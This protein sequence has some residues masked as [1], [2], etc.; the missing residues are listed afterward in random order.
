M[1]SLGSRFAFYRVEVDER[2]SQTRRALI[3]RRGAKE[4]RNELREAVSALFAGIT[5][6]EEDALTDS[7][8]DRLVTVADLVTMARSPI[9]RDRYSREI[10]LVP[11]P[12][13]PARF[14]LIL[15]SLLEGLY[16]IGVEREHA[17]KLVT[18]VA[19]DSMPAQR[20]Q[21]IRLLAEV[22]TTTTKKV[23]MGLGLPTT[24]ARR[25]LE[26]LT[27]HRLVQREEGEDD[28]SDTWR[29]TAWTRDKYRESTV[30]A[31]SV[32]LCPIYPVSTND[33]FAGTMF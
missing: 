18:K 27:A 22:E 2:D 11:D 33:D 12:E 3:H 23:A 15:A 14:A 1:D 16:A 17:W 30:P 20:R 25:V 28:P 10:E 13:A 6:P 5:L 26:D 21:V 4:M 19:F 29:L 32:E 31:K 24:T 7:D 8:R 9:E